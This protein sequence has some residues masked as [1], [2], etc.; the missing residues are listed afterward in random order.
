MQVLDH[1]WLCN[2]ELKALAYQ[3]YQLIQC[4]TSPMRPTKVVNLYHEL[5]CMSCL[6]HWMKRLKW[7][8]Y[9]HNQKDPLIQNQ[10]HLPISI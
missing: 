10:D 5:W 6:W 8:G 1:F 4:I 9:G 3:F 2:L 7:V